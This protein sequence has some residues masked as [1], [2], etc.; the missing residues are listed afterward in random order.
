M[1]NPSSLRLFASALLLLTCAMALHVE[2]GGSGLNTVVIVNQNSAQS[3]ELGNYYCERRQVPP[4][5]VLRINWGGGNISWS[6]ADF[7]TNLVTPLLA[8]LAARQHPAGALG[9]YNPEEQGMAYHIV[10]FFNLLLK[11]ENYLRN[12]GHTKE[13]E[14]THA[15][16]A[17]LPTGLVVH[18]TI[19]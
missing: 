8:M 10:D 11:N 15:L 6:S 19:H 7:Q 5:N 13:F 3:C 18:F 14:A 4:E 2:A 12:S 9:I 17:A 16:I 1:H